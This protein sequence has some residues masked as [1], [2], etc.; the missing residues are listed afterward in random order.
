[1][2]PLSTI[3]LTIENF[4]MSVLCSCRYSQDLLVPCS[5]AQN[6][7]NI[8][9]LSSDYFQMQPSTQSL[10]STLHSQVF[11]HAFYLVSVDFPIFFGSQ[12]ARFIIQVRIKTLQRGNSTRDETKSSCLIID[13]QK[14]GCG[15]HHSAFGHY[16]L[17]VEC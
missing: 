3:D 5:L 17:R 4:T 10:E 7:A 6:I 8:C 13:G 15:P 11:P 2:Y 14:L 12:K 9:L 1:M 16:V